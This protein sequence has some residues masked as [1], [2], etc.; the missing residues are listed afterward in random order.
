MTAPT[1]IPEKLSALA[2][3]KR[4]GACRQVFSPCSLD[5]HHKMLPCMTQFHN[6]INI[7]V[8][9][10]NNFLNWNTVFAAFHASSSNAFSA[11]LVQ[12]SPLS[13]EPCWPFIHRQCPFYTHL[14]TPLCG[15]TLYFCYIFL[16][17]PLL[18]SLHLYPFH[19][20]FH[21][22]PPAQFF[23]FFLSDV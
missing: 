7:A 16:A 1:S 22:L 10:L 11:S 4:G 21:T 15:S 2:H 23:F 17:P 20:S 5:S 3:S 13:V 6:I 12:H 9:F 18:R 8:V 19:P 14:W